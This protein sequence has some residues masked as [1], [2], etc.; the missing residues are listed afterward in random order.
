MKQLLDAHQ[1]ETQIYPRAS[2]RKTVVTKRILVADDDEGIRH[3]ISSALADDG[4]A[5][6][7]ASDGEQAWEALHHE[8][9]DLL[10][11]DNEM[12]RL[13]G[14]KLIE[15]IRKEGMSLPVIIASGTCSVERVRNDP[16]LQIAAVIPKPFDLLELLDTVRHALQESGETAAANHGAFH[17]LHANPQ[18]IR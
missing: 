11:T 12:P 18:P 1:P 8:H 9:Y 2:A 7:A 14:I 4:F 16:Q 10:V 3:L 15:R 6:N 17:Q 13:A 5:V